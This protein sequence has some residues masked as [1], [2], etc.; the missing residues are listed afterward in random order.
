M[1]NTFLKSYVKEIVGMYDSGDKFPQ[2]LTTS[3]G[4]LDETRARVLLA[5]LD[6]TM[7]MKRLADSAAIKVSYPIVLEYAASSEVCLKTSGLFQ[8]FS[9]KLLEW[10]QIRAK[11]SL[12]ALI[13]H[14]ENV[15]HDAH[16]AHDKLPLESEAQNLNE[17]SD[18]GK[19]SLDLILVIMSTIAKLYGYI[20]KNLANEEVYPLL[21]ELDVFIGLIL[22][23]WVPKN[24]DLVSM[25]Q[26]I[27]DLWLARSKATIKLAGLLCEIGKMK[28][29][30]DYDGE[31]G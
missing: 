10:L 7:S 26:D 3:E 2:Y 17:F 28:G 15:L 16:D 31:R 11:E 6:R 30:D 20:F 1:A 4:K 27:S 13:E 29:G 12:E 8:D 25:R 14:R 9:F 21:N 18:I 5:S 19:Y 22:R 23:D 24:A